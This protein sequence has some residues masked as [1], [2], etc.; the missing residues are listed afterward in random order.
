VTLLRHPASV[1]EV[2]PGPFAAG[3]TVLQL[4]WGPD[5]PAALTDLAGLVEAR[6]IGM[7]DGRLRVGALTS[8][9]D[10]RTDPMVRRHAPL[11]AQ[12]CG[13]IGALGV[14]MLGT[15][16]GNIG[17]R[18]GDSVP[19]LLAL[20][21]LVETMEGLI[22]LDAVLAQPVIPL[23]LAVHIPPP[24]AVAVF[25]KIGHRA[26][27]SLSAVTVAGCIDGGTVRLAAGAAGQPARRL[28]RAEAQFGVGLAAAIAAE[29][30]WGP[31][32]VA[33]RVLAGLLSA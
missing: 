5:G 18:C 31:G 12:A 6:G 8:L 7:V 11:L 29:I 14:R 16:G 15:L 9:E 1:A 30:D 33:G 19:A 3:C 20:G 32:V 24:P 22:P 27:F 28:R 10:C 4:S 23:L 26:A 21:A 2:G 17:W 25:E 13:V